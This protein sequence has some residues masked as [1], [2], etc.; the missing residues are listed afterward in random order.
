MTIGIDDEIYNQLVAALLTSRDDDAVR[1][2]LCEIANIVPES[3]RALS[4]EDD[5]DNRT[6]H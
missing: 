6:R 5:A 2:A 3:I 4:D 1:V